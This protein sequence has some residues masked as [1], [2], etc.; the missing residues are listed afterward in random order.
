MLKH[1]GGDTVKAGFYW[2][3]REWEAT[4]VPHESGPL[5]GDETV[6]F[7]RT[8]W[9]ALLV[10]APVMGGLFAMFLPFI[11]LAMLAAFLTGRLRRS[12]TTDPPAAEQRVED[13]R[14]A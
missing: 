10:L 8:P 6:T 5:P 13:K 9:P 12:R 11:G 4:I 7:Y 3:T 14:A 2:N 1:K